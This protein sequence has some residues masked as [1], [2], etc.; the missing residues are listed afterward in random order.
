MA[1]K[2]RLAS[3]L[4]EKGLDIRESASGRR[5]VATVELDTTFARVLG[6]QD[7]QKV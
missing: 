7:A 5:D 2:T 6:L 3:V 1:S 4:N